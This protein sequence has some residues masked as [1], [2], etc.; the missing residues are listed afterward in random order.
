LAFRDDERSYGT[1]RDQVDEKLGDERVPVL[2][3]EV[4][5]LVYRSVGV[6]F[7][8]FLVQFYPSLPSPA[9]SLVNPSPEVNEDKEEA[10]HQSDCHSGQKVGRTVWASLELVEGNGECDVA[11]QE[12][13]RLAS[14]D[15]TEAQEV[16]VVL[17]DA[18]FIDVDFLLLHLK[19]VFFF[20]A[21]RRR[22]LKDLST[23]Y[24]A[25]W[26]C[27]LNEMPCAGPPVRR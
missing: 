15:I 20:L 2:S 10:S 25:G 16:S 17:L 23:C 3:G 21:H 9:Q 13:K 14:L 27:G 22:P 4:V 26:V 11:G 6:Q 19:Q 12:L 5:R 7:V 1:G 24:F 18:D 8:Q